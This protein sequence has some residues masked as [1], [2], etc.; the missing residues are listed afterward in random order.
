[1]NTDRDAKFFLCF[2]TPD[3]QQVLKDLERMYQPPTFPLSDGDLRH[4]VGQYSVVS[5][6]NSEIQ[7]GGK[8][9]DTGST[10]T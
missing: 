6:I 8:L 2:S 3:G 7:K 5:F 4:A 10:N 9:N 1:M